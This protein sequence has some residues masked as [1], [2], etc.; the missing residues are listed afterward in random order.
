M[1]GTFPKSNATRT[2]YN[3]KQRERLCR[4]DVSSDSCSVARKTRARRPGPPIRREISTGKGATPCCLAK[5]VELEEKKR[6]R[7]ELL[8][9]KSE[10]SAED[11]GSKGDRRSRG[12]EEGRDPSLRSLGLRS[13]QAGPGILAGR[14]FW[15]RNVTSHNSMLLVICQGILHGKQPGLWKSRAGRG[16]AR[17]SPLLA[18]VRALLHA[19]GSRRGSQRVCIL[20]RRAESNEYCDDGIELALHDATDF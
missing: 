7:R 5:S 8:C 18:S 12:G 1:R 15:G 2:G 10:K 14:S 11:T 3:P 4:G 20:T 9:T 13:G 6:V 19:T 17:S 16:I